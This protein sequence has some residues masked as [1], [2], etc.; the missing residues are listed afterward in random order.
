MDYKVGDVLILE[1][2]NNNQ[3]Y[4]EDSTVRV[5]ITEV[6]SIYKYY[7]KILSISD[8]VPAER[9]KWNVSLLLEDPLFEFKFPRFA[10]R[11]KYNDNQY[12]VFSPFSE[13]GFLPHDEFEY[14]SKFGYNTA[15]VN[16]ARLIKI[17]NFVPSSDILP[18][19]VIAI[20]I[21]YKED[22]A[23]LLALS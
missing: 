4:Q 21:L 3:E 23:K 15:M 18:Y 7:V 11:Y 9:V 5:I 14:D 1:L 19:D 17:Q 8:D 22:K 20:D 2:E 10:Y 13:V 16:T 6:E 12:S